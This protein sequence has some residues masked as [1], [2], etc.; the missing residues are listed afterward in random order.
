MDFNRKVQQFLIDPND[1]PE[2]NWAYVVEQKLGRD[3]ADAMGR[4]P[5]EELDW[6]T[7]KRP[8]HFRLEANAVARAEDLVKE[9]AWGVKFNQIIFRVSP[10]YVGYVPPADESWII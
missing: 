1:Q 8:N 9:F 4:D 6:E 10:K 5:R 7:V 2:E 3:L